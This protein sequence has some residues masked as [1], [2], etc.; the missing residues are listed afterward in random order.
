MS[1]PKEGPGE[2]LSLDSE[3]LM[4]EEKILGTSNPTPHQVLLD[5]RFELPFGMQA[6]QRAVTKNY[7][8]LNTFCVYMNILMHMCLYEY[9]R[10]F[11][12]TE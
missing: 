1:I 11:I 4:R 2:W 3:V 10:V 7:S 5:T 9:T 8:Y 6:N 12:S